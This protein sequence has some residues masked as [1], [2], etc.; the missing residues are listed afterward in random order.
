MVIRLSSLQ[1]HTRRRLPSA[2]FTKNT[3]A[4]TGDL[5]GSMNPQPRRVVVCFCN[6]SINGLGS[7]YGVRDGGEDPGTKSKSWLIALSGG[8]ECGSSP[9]RTS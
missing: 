5:L 8:S 7:L 2:F 6:S 9:G 4:P 3:G 1:S